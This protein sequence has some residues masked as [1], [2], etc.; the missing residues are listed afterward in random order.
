[1]SLAEE[2]FEFQE[3]MHG[4]NL[5]KKLTP[6]VLFVRDI[7]RE[8]IR[9]AEERRADMI[10]LQGYWTASRHGF[11]AKSEMK[12]AANAHCSVAVLLSSAPEM[13]TK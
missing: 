13:K 10:I 9:F 12:I 3:A 11:L 2:E 7:S 5:I 4:L 1:L 8:V 6:R